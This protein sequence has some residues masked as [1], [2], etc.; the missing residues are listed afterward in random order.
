[1]LRFF[2][3]FLFGEG[4]SPLKISFLVQIGRD[5]ILRSFLEEGS[6]D[7]PRRTP[8]FA[9]DDSLFGGGISRLCSK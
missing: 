4:F 9:R 2:T 8:W 5:D 6:L 3:S 1:M 7:Y